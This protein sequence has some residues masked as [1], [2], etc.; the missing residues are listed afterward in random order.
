MCRGVCSCER[1]KN[2]KEK[3]VPSVWSKGRRLLSCTRFGRGSRV[4]PCEGEALQQRGE[5]GGGGGGGGQSQRALGQSVS[6]SVDPAATSPASRLGSLRLCTRTVSGVGPQPAIQASPP[7][8]ALFRDSS[9]LD[10]LGFQETNI[11]AAQARQCNAIYYC[12]CVNRV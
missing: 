12:D 8:Q 10:H 3:S 5:R 11:Q 2:K 4:M 6:Q 9:H 1:E 7:S